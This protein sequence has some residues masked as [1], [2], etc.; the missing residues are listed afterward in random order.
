[1][2]VGTCIPVSVTGRTGTHA[3][4][5]ETERWVKLGDKDQPFSTGA[6]PHGPLFLSL[7]LS[8]ANNHC[9][10]HHSGPRY[11]HKW[12]NIHFQYFDAPN[13]MANVASRK[14]Q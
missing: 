14:M 11:V 10:Q 2:A 3:F 6:I 4:E 7:A 12:Q 9:L 8:S 5:T 13:A 1:M